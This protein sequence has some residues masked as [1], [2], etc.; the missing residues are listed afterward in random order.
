MLMPR[1]PALSAMRA[2]SSSGPDRTV[3]VEPLT[4][5]MPVRSGVPQAA[6]RARTSFS[7][8]STALMP[9]PAGREAMRRPRAATRRAAS[10]RL[11]TPA[12]VAATYSPMLCPAAARGWIPKDCHIRARAYSRLN[13]AGWVKAV[14]S[15][16]AALSASH[17]TRSRG[18]GSRGSKRRAQRS[19][20]ARKHGCAW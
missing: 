14:L 11:N 8:A 2:R 17:M 5:A 15:S 20:S 6:S 1:L 18:S 3:C 4:A 9:P 7:E 13:R 12:R 19:S 16:S 10:S